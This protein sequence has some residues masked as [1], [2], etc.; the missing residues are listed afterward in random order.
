MNTS[1]SP[2]EPRPP[3]YTEYLHRR[4]FSDFQEPPVALTE[5]RTR[6]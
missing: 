1:N 6:R 5:H 2:Q 3:S 4:L